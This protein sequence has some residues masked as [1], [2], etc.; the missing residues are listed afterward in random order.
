MNTRLEEEKANTCY[1]GYPLTIGVYI[2][3]LFCYLLNSSNIAWSIVTKSEV[4]RA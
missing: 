2:R 1:F 3:V 4:G